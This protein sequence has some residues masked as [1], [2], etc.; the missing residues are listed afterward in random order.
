MS[1]Q[2]RVFSPEF[3]L[4][5][6]KRILDGESVSK[7]QAELKSSAACYTDCEISIARKVPRVW[8][9]WQGGSREYP[10]RP[11]PS[12]GPARRSLCASK[13]QRCNARSA[14]R[15]CNWIFSKEPSSE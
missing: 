12:R 2:Y 5:V 4:Q 10:I 8:S 13:W 15:R 1:S 9:A 11:S 3:R 6:V 7:L 14:I